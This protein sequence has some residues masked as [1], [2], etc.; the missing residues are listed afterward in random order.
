MSVS[1]D[2]LAEE[3]AELLLALVS[4]PSPSSE[5]ANVQQAIISW[6]SANGIAAQLE[7][8]LDGLSNVVVEIEGAGPGPV[9][10]IGGHC[11]TVSP[12]PDY[13]FDPYAPFVKDGRLYGLGA[14][15]MKGGLATAMHVAREFHRTRSEWTG[16][17]IFA[18]LA[19]EEA[20]SRGSEGFVAIPRRIDA[21]IIC[22]PS[23]QPES[24]GIGKVNVRVEVTGVSAHGSFPEGGVNAV[25]EAGRLLARIADIKHSAHPVHGA[26]SHCVLNITSGDRPYEIRVPDYCTFLIN[27]HFMPHEKAEDAV[28]VLEGLAAELDSKARFDIKLATPRYDSYELPDDHPLVVAFSESY[29]AVNGVRPEFKFSYGISDANVFT[30]AGIPTLLFGPYG[31]NMH[32][33]D[34]WV[35]I[36]QMVKAHAIYSDFILRF[37]SSQA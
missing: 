15:D 18:A 23:P 22:E 6:F 11:D 14:M 32:A 17:V 2:T 26:A 30:A 31:E 7:P 24:G 20:F 25:V 37:L 13:S 4:I 29:A 21:A 16:K 8:A 27:W 35:D 34:E 33:A 19:D 10:W 9:V 12:A 3:L 5:E 28:A 36:D 1:K